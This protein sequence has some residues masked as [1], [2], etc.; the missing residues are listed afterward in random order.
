MRLQM[1]SLIYSNLLII[2]VES[3]RS[4]EDSC[5]LYCFSK[6]NTFCRSRF[7]FVVA[8][9]WEHMRVQIDAFDRFSNLFVYLVVFSN[10]VINFL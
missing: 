3:H 8:A 2:E 10:L 6:F 4:Y 1:N 7:R 5:Q 9:A